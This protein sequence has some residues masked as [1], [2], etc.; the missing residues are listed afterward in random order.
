MVWEKSL[1]VLSILWGLVAGHLVDVDSEDHDWKHIYGTATWVLVAGHL[2]GVDS[3]D[4]VWAHI[5]TG[6]SLEG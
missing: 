1:K 2:V 3:E 6:L 5:F 4:H